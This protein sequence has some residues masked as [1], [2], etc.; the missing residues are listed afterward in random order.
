MSVAIKRIILISKTKFKLKKLLAG[1]YEINQASKNLFL[2]NKF[3]L[4]GKLQSQ[5]VFKRK[6]YNYLLFGYLIK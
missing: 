1:C 5:I 2:K 4:E 6:R 3:K